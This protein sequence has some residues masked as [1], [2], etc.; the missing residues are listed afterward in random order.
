[1]EALLLFELGLPTLEQL[2]FLILEIKVF[3]AAYTALAARD[4]SV[5]DR[6]PTPDSILL[7]APLQGFFYPSFGFCEADQKKSRSRPKEIRILEK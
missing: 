2:E 3:L 1:L 7:I 5:N 6:D 4:I